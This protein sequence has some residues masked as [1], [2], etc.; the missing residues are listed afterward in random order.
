[1]SVYTWNLKTGVKWMGVRM[2][3]GATG[4]FLRVHPPTL[5]KSRYILPY[6]CSTRGGPR[7]NTSVVFHFLLPWLP[8]TSQE[9][10]TKTVD[11]NHNPIPAPLQRLS[12]TPDILSNGIS[13]KFHFWVILVHKNLVSLGPKPLAIPYSES[14]FLGQHLQSIGRGLS[15]TSQKIEATFSSLF[16]IAFWGE[17]TIMWTPPPSSKDS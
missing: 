7:T 6:F 13:G 4:Q 3:R 15:H 1:M 14:H 17:K 9:C 10:C 12:Q 2:A 16:I 11:G 8:S 5:G